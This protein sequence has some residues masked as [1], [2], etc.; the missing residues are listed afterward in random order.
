MVDDGV[1]PVDG[2]LPTHIQL[3]HAQATQAISKALVEF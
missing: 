1:T 3:E 2:L